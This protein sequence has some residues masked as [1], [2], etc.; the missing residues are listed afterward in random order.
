MVIGGY[1]HAGTQIVD[2]LLAV[3]QAHITVASRNLA[4]ASR[5]VHR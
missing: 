2:L 5:F 4:R 3:C 1:G